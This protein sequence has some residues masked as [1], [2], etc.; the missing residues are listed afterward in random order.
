MDTM[1]LIRVFVAVLI[2]DL[3]LTFLPIP[4]LPIPFGLGDGVMMG[5]IAVILYWLLESVIR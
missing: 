4:Y 3:A 5:I 1:S 2:A